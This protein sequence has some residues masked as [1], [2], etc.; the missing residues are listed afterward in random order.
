MFLDSAQLVAAH[1]TSGISNLILIHHLLVRSQPQNQK[2]LPLP[3]TV[4]E[5][6]KEDY[7]KWMDSLENE[8][9]GV[10]LA[11][12]AISKGSKLTEAQLKEYP[13][14]KLILEIVSKE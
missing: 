13:E 9:E 5:L 4:Y 2:S 3:H 8:Q 1:H 7:M 11:M 12:D 10:Q 14:Y 6:S